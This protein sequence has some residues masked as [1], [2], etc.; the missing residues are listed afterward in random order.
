MTYRTLMVERHGGAEWVTLNRP[1]RRNAVDELMREEL[2]QYLDRVA[3]DTEIR[4]L[5]LR[6][7]G[8]GFCSGLDLKANLELDHPASPELA[9]RRL[10]WQ[11]RWSQLAVKLRRAP[12]PIVALVN[13]HAAGLGFSLALAADIR[14]ASE[15]AIFSAAFITL[16]FSG[17]DCGSSYHLPRIVGSSV[18]R[19]LLM[20]GRH[21]SAERALRIGLVSD[22]V[23]EAELM[24]A[25]QSMVDDLLATGSNGLRLTKDLINAAESGL[26]LE[27]QIAIEDRNQMY[28]LAAGDPVERIRAFA[29]KRRGSTTTKEPGR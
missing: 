2:H 10:A 17:G 1:E 9:H 27:D 3:E 11:R 29:Q 22:V 5:V 7:A 28:C 18:A 6:G 26:G 8:Q 19:E 23:P 15:S 21:C 24:R 4:V 16:G 14:I 25:G 12:Q 13:G 20:T